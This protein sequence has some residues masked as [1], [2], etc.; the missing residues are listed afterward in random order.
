MLR[1]VR[2]EF[3]GFGEGG[4][5]SNSRATATEEHCHTSHIS[6]HTDATLVPHQITDKVTAI[7]FEFLQQHDD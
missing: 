7:R 2:V 4:D 3:R 6:S 1:V 5:I